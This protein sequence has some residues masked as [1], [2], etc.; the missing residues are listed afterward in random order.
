MTTTLSSPS[1]SPVYGSAE[2]TSSAAPATLPAA[3][4]L[5]ERVLVDELAA[6]RVDDPHSRPHPLDRRGVDEAARLV[7]QREVERE[8]VGGRQDLIRRSPTC[9]APS[10][11]NRSGA[12]KGS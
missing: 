11:R 12:T 2:K 1:S 8:E 7:R 5:R 3:D 9:S 4:R 6:G 10:S